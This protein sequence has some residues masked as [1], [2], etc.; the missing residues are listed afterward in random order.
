M[1]SN[2]P[3]GVIPLNT[4]LE[5]EITSIEPISHDILGDFGYKYLMD[6][7]SVFHLCL[8]FYILKNSSSKKNIYH[9]F[10]FYHYIRVKGHSLCLLLIAE[11]LDQKST[12]KS[13]SHKVSGTFSSVIWND[14]TVT[15][16]LMV[17]LLVAPFL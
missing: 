9:L 12:E 17:F 1:W 15:T 2:S 14:S 13:A 4:I 8:I 16:M 3:R 11:R 10:A 5:V 7:I 6:N